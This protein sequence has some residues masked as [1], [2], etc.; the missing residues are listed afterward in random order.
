MFEYIKNKMNH[1]KI[2]VNQL[3]TDNEHLMTRGVE[4][5][6]ENDLLKAEIKKLEWYQIQWYK[7]NGLTSTTE[8]D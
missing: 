1:L 5:M 7:S 8:D 3:E 4:T 2:L 6:K